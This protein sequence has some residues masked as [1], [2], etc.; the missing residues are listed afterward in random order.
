MS[1]FWLDL[2]ALEGKNKVQKIKQIF[3]DFQR[4]F[5]VGSWLEAEEDY[6]DAMKEKIIEIINGGSI[7]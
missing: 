5:G 1:L 2:K 6:F 3:D 7:E 4:F